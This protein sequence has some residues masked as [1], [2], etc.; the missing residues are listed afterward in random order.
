MNKEMTKEK[1][2]NKIETIFDHNPTEEEL[3]YLTSAHSKEEYLKKYNYDIDDCYYDLAYLYNHRDD[4]A[5]AKKYFNM[6]S[7]KTLKRYKHDPNE[8]F[9]VTEVNGKLY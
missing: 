1:N 7:E 6:Q 4:Y 8:D 9:H 2:I 3:E 5:T